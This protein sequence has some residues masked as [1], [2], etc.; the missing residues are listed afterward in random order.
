M[1]KT[2]RKKASRQ[3]RKQTQVGGQTPSKTNYTFYFAGSDPTGSVTTFFDNYDAA[4]NGVAGTTC[5]A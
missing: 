1:R 2:P 4:G 5:A 3:T